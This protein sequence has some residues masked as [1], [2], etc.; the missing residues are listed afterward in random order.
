MIR[1]SSHLNSA[2]RATLQ[3]IGIYNIK[4]LVEQEKKAASFYSRCVDIF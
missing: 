4:T 2:E 3:N 1:P